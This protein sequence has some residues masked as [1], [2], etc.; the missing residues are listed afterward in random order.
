MK[1]IEGV[2]RSGR[3][4][5]LSTIGYSKGT[6]RSE[7]TTYHHTLT[8]D[9]HKIEIELDEED[10]PLHKG[11][12]VIMAGSQDGDLF[13]A[14]AY[15]NMAT[16]KSGRSG[17]GK[18][19]FILAAL[20]AAGGLGIL[21]VMFIAEGDWVEKGLFGIV[22]LV[23]L[24]L[25]RYIGGASVRGLLAMRAIARHKAQT[26]GTGAENMTDVTKSSS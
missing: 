20:V 5:A 13:R 4:Q 7:S 12:R 19:G 11:H 17:S 22:A 1:V 3:Q 21:I 8:M 23:L 15:N 6:G 14:Y 10:H 2:L 9:D 16:R 26:S 18:L 24:N 25:A